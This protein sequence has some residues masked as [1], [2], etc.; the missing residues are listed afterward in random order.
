MRISP[1]TNAY[2][3]NTKHRRVV[4]ESINQ[5]SSVNF[6]GG[7]KVRLATGA[8]TGTAGAVIGFCLGGPLGAV[9]GG[10][11]TGGLGAAME[12]EDGKSSTGDNNF[13]DKRD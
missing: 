5:N 12:S 9:I 10:A 2:G 7:N 6:Q 8:L 4:P 1:I 13:Y 11:L 3:L